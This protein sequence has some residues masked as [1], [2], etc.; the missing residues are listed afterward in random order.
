MTQAEYLGGLGLG[1]W[2]RAIRTM[3]LGQ[4][5][6]QANAMAMRHLVDP[7]GLGN[8]KVL[9]Q[10]KGTGIDDMNAIMPDLGEGDL[11]DPPL[12]SREHMRLMEG[13]YAHTAWQPTWED[14]AGDRAD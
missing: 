2:V 5:E 3:P 1:S 4:N 12:L 7:S 9:V 6:M 14:P 13:R 10:E 11:G 8:F